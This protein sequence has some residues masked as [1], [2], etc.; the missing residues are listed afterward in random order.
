VSG[1]HALT[2]AHLL[3]ELLENATH[4]SNPDTRVVV[5]A[6]VTGH[7]VDVTVTD[8]GLAC[9]RGDR[10]RQREDRHP[11]WPRSRSRSDSDCS[12]SG[13][14]PPGWA[15]RSSSAAAAPRA[16]WSPWPAQ[17]RVRGLRPAGGGGRDA[18]APVFEAAPGRG[19]AVRRCREACRRGACRRAG[20]R[21]VRGGRADPQGTAATRSPPGPGR[22]PSAPLR[23]PHRGAR[24]G[25][26]ASWTRSTRSDEAIE[27][28]GRVVR[29]PTRHG[30]RR[31]PAG[32]QGPV[33]ARS[34]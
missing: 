16:P 9:R 12:S 10:R 3:A 25:R 24:A 7:G 4:F 11:R 21:P 26:R 34:P 15:R 28:R 33:P 8:Y 29:Q 14:S 1:R 19:D 32:P 17:Q 31:D 2:V 20:V 13:G 18:V 22:S 5:S 27:D 6:S 23:R 30:V